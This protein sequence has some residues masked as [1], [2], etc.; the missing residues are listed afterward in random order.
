MLRGK[1]RGGLRLYRH[2][3]PGR[4]LLPGLG[5]GYKV[6]LRSL[7]NL[8]LGSAAP[9][10]DFRLRGGF[11]SDF[12][13]N[14]FGVLHRRIPRSLRRGQRGMVKGIHRCLLLYV[15]AYYRRVI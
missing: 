9:R 3:L 10:G 6:G 11:R 8:G 12:A 13:E 2:F 14:G 7:G 4:C 5:A 15:W 1:L